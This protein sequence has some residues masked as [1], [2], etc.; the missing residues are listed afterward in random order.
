MAPRGPD[1]V[2]VNAAVLLQ[3]ADNVP[4]IVVKALPQG[5]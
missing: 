1:G 5:S 4:A 2:P 3:A